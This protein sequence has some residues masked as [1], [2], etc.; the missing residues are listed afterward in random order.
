MTADHAGDISLFA[1]DYAQRVEAGEHGIGGGQA[2]GV[3]VDPWLLAGIDCQPCIVN[4]L[5]F[6]CYGAGAVSCSEY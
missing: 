6:G 3:V 5:A 4:V 2:I 1:H